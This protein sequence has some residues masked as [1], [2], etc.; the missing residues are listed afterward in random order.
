LLPLFQLID[1]QFG[2]M[3]TV[4]GPRHVGLDHICMC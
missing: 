4:P 1:L 3:Q 2:L